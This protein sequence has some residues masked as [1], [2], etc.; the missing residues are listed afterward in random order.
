MNHFTSM[1]QTSSTLIFLNN[2]NNLSCWAILHS[3]T[4]FGSLHDPRP[5]KQTWEVEKPLETSF[6]HAGVYDELKSVAEAW[7]KK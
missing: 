2:K 6:S 7:T 3:L 5:L 1:A 4:D